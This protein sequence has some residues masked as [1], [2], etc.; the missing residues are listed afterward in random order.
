MATRFQYIFEHARLGLR[1]EKYGGSRLNRVAI[2]FRSKVISISGFHFRFRDRHLR[3]RCRPM[4]GHIVSVRS[5][6]GV[7]E[8]MG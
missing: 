4:S 2:N 7:V 8:N 1:S 3:F 5:E 6:S